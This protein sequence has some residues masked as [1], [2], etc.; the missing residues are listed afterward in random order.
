MKTKVCPMLSSLILKRDATKFPKRRFV[1]PGTFDSTYDS[2]SNVTAKS[3]G[4]SL[5]VNLGEQAA[6][7]GTQSEVGRS[8]EPGHQQWK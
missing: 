8:E 3:V 7:L 4:L 5:N 2:P 1:S 6:L